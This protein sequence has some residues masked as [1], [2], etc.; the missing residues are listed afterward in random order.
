VGA[1]AGIGGITLQSLP[2]FTDMRGDVIE[3]IV[4][5]LIGDG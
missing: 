3:L 2:A 5:E 1:P 4:I